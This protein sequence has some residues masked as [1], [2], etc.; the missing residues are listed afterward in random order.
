MKY[1]SILPCF[2]KFYSYSVSIYICVLIDIVQAGVKYLYIQ[3]VDYQSQMR[4]NI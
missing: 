2:I 3:G 4:R 1:R